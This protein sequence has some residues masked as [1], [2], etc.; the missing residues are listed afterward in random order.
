MTRSATVHVVLA[1]VLLVP[2]LACAGETEA[3]SESAPEAQV[4]VVTAPAVGE[5][6]GRVVTSYGAVEADPDATDVVAL[7]RAGVIR[8]VLV[9]PG[10]R[11]QAGQGLVEL[12]TAPGPKLQWEQAQAAVKYAEQQ[13]ARI[14]RMAA[15]RLATTDQLAQARRDLSDAQASERSLRSVG[16]DTA[17]QLLRAT[18]DAIVTQVLVNVGDRTSADAPALNLAPLDGLIVRLGVEPEIARQ[19]PAGASVTVASVFDPDRVFDGMAKRVHAMLDPSTRRVDVIVAIAEAE[20]GALTIGEQMRG[21]IAIGE[22]DA[23]VVP[24]SALLRDESGDYVFTAVAGQAHRIDVEIVLD[25]TSDAAIR[26]DL[27]AGNAVVVSG[28][29]Q[30]SEG[31]HVVSERATR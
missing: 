30:L 31:T 5:R 16:A 10:E 27:V 25:R 9:R 19:M 11:V 3:D 6:V 12:D 8:R 22:V 23:I 26:G 20:A 28:G 2:T 24:R 15:S 21:T 13:L 1:S 4:V 29:Y 14:E 7:P 17:Q 18:K